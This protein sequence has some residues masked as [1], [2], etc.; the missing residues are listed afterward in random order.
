MGIRGIRYLDAGSRGQDGHTGSHN[1]VVF[2]PQHIKIKRKYAKGGE[3][4]NRDDEGIVAYAFGNSIPHLDKNY[5]ETDTNDA[6]PA[7]GVK[8]ID[9]MPDETAYQ[10]IKVGPSNVSY[11]EHPSHIEIS[12]V[13]TPQ[14]HRGKGAAS[15]ALNALHEIADKKARR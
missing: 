1:I 8:A 4:P 10:D 5:R 2:D 7:Q 14:K 11:K 15:S 13:R 12:S 6:L 9:E 3:I